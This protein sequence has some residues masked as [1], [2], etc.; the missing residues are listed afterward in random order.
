MWQFDKVEGAPAVEL[1]APVMAVRVL[2]HPKSLVVVIVLDDLFGLAVG[3]CVRLDQ[4]LEGLGGKLALLCDE[5][6][7]V[8]L[9]NVCKQIF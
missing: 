9:A 6:V 4:L 7:L 5:A 8:G 1:V 2:I 3:P